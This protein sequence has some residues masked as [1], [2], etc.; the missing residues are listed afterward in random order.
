[1]C[2]MLYLLAL[3]YVHTFNFLASTGKIT[4][5]HVLSLTP[6]NKVLNLEYSPP[7]GMHLPLS[8][9]ESP[10]LNSLATSTEKQA[11]FPRNRGQKLISFSLTLVKRY[12][13]GD[14]SGIPAPSEQE[15]RCVFLETQDKYCNI[16]LISLSFDFD[17]AGLRTPRSFRPLTEETLI[18]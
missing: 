13:L 14:Y 11:C 5:V 15:S 7:C 1:M 6:E 9:W 17:H 18:S 8:F 10:S 16:I 2:T 4:V 3:K 12:K